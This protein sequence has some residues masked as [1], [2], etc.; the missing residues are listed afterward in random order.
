MTYASVQPLS[1]LMHFKL[2]MLSVPSRNMKSQS[3]DTVIAFGMF[4]AYREAL[5]STAVFVPL[6]ARGKGYSILIC[7]EVMTRLT[8]KRSTQNSDYKTSI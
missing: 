1:I 6:C 5:S 7:M 3:M 2:T 8:R 4:R